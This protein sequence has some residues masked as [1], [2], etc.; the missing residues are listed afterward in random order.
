MP[1]T[2]TL[3]MTTSWALLTNANVTEATFQNIGASPIY[4]IGTNGVTPPSDGSFGVLY[5]PGE[6]E[7]R[8]PL[9]DMFPG[10]T[11]VNRLWSRSSSLPTGVFV[12]HA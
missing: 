11:D 9:V 4:V 3:N 6:G 7:A 2:T 5:N 8:R 12:S 10:V 1:Q